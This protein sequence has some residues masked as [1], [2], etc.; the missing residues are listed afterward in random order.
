MQIFEGSNRND[1]LFSSILHCLFE[2]HDEKLCYE[3]AQVFNAK[4]NVINFY[5]HSLLD[6]HYAC[7]FITTCSIK[8]L[9]VSMYLC[10]FKA[11]SD[12]Y[13]DTIAKY[14]QNTS[15]SISSFYLNIY[16]ALSHK[17]MQEFA[18]TLSTQPNL[19]SLELLGS[20]VPGCLKILC[21]SICRHNSNL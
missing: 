9:K 7:Y 4:K 19:Y 5:M 21:N 3:F 20:C 14:L 1:E 11:S 13:C 10:N 17:G 6:C 2:A 15:C 16:G 18:K 12:L 8:E